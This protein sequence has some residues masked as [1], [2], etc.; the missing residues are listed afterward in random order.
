MKCLDGD[1]LAQFRLR[2]ENSPEP[3]NANSLA[4]YNEGL[5]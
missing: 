3:E 4:G 5:A 1:L 2:L